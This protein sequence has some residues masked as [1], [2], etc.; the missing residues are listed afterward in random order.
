[1]ADE[2]PSIPRGLHE[3]LTCEPGESSFQR[4][5]FVCAKRWESVPVSMMLAPKVSRSM[6]AVHRGGMRESEVPQLLDAEMV[7]VFEDAAA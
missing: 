6:M 7:K 2:I 5:F 3:A 1:M 4:W